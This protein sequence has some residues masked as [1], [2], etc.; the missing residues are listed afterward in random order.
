MNNSE[1][2]PD[3]NLYRVRRT[4][5]DIASQK[6]AF[7]LLE[8]AV[9]TAE[10]FHL[11]VFD[12][13]GTKV[14]EGGKEMNSPY[15]GKF[16]V[17]QEFKGAAH[18]GLDLVGVDSKS[19]YSTV[20][21][22]VEIAGYENNANHKQ[23]F[24]LYVRILAEG[25]A[26]RYYF[27]HL[28]AVAVK[29]GQKVKKGDLLGTEGSTGNSTGSHCHY[30]ARTNCSKTAYL[31]IPALSGIPN[32]I[33]SY[34][35]GT[36]APVEKPA[37]KTA[38]KSTE[39]LA[40]EVLFG[41]WGNGEDRKKRLTAAGYDYSLIQ[42]KVNELANQTGKRSNAQIAREVIAGHWGNGTTRKTRLTQAGYD[43]GTIQKI[44]NSMLK[45]S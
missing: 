39:A 35:A 31:N 15:K 41:L 10:R 38:A 3:L 23:G 1:W 27:G 21:G 45:G 9:I 8:A 44:V 32:A 37:A 16:R 42:K 26:D 30:C 5:E 20:S 17:S 19:I 36:Q 13:F 34:T 4:F 7:F 28:S 18:D 33:G 11:N 25:S 24:G 6:G 2:H 40:K 14:Y 12:R 22:K 43:Y 29:V